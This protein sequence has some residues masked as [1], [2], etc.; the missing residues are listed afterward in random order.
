MLK[1]PHA[2]ENV[3]NKKKKQKSQVCTRYARIIGSKQSSV[4]IVYRYCNIY[5]NG[6]NLLISILMPELLISGVLNI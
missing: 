2:I 3:L 1:N 5:R 6:S 4:G